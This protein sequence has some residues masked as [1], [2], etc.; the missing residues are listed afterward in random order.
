MDKDKIIKIIPK[1]IYILNDI[2]KKS[3]KKLYLVGGSVRDFITGDKPKDFDL[4]TDAMPCEIKKIISDEYGI[5]KILPNEDLILNSGIRINLQGESFGVIVIYGMDGLWGGVEI[6][7]FRGG[8]NSSSEN[9]K[10]NVSIT[11][12]I[13]RRDLTINSMFYDLDKNEIIDLLGG[14]ED[15]ENGRLRMVGN[16]NDRLKDDP[17]RI[18]R[19]FRFGIKYDLL[20]DDETKKA[21]Y[22]NKHLYKSP[23]AERPNGVSQER[24]NSE[25]ESAFRYDFVKYLEYVNEFEMWDVLYPNSDMSNI[26]VK[27]FSTFDLTMVNLFKDTDLKNISKYRFSSKFIEL[28]KLSSYLSEETTETQAIMIRKMQV[29]YSISDDSMLDLIS[30]N[31]ITNPNVLKIVLFDTK[32]VKSIEVMDKYGI[33]HE[34]DGTLVNKRDGKKLGESMFVE[35]LK[36]F[37]TLVCS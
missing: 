22:T 36:Y 27:I 35:Q 17:L 24:I 15:L 26:D 30:I 4:T 23:T 14:I 16:P 18:Q 28:N 6:A 5:I 34:A 12:D 7:T 32:F 29:K 13:K 37:K 31:N 25:M 33:Q 3:N 8:E 21:I 2:F 10:F 20:M 1:S 9:I 19:L 11:E